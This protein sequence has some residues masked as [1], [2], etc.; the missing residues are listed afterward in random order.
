MTNL[1]S[2]IAD[3]CVHVIGRPCSRIELIT[4]IQRMA[5]VNRAWPNATVKQWEK[6]IDEA[7]N[8]GLLSRTSETIWIPMVAEEPKA[9][10][11][12]LF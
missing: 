9:K 10:Q 2:E 5:S 1:A 11:G 4:E 3:F 8:R 7:V 6:A 12:E